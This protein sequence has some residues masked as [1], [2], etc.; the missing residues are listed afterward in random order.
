MVRIINRRKGEGT[1]EDMNNLASYLLRSGLVVLDTYGDGE[2]CGFQEGSY[3]I[4]DYEV[5]VIK[6]KAR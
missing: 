5:H 4:C 6:K 2:E 3:A 1:V